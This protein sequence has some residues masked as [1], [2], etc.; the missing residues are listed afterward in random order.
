M[1][2]SVLGG[3]PRWMCSKANPFMRVSPVVFRRQFFRR[4]RVE[5]ERSHVHVDTGRVASIRR[6]LK[7]LGSMAECHATMPSSAFFSHS[8]VSSLVNLLYQSFNSAVRL[9]SVPPSVI[10][11]ARKSVRDLKSPSWCEDRGR[12]G[13]VGRRHW[14]P[15]KIDLCA[16]NLDASCSMKVSRNGM[17]T[18]AR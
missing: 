16:R 5:K 15:H 2:F 11:E 17:M 13:F 14:K 7:T 6:S 8:F 9:S 1:T 18:A 3:R 12:V 4:W 10:A